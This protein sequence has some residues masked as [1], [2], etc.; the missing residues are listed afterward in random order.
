MAL[1]QLAVTYLPFM[2]NIFGTTP[3]KAESWLAPIL[4]GLVVFV[5]VEIEKFAIRRLNT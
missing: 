3:L 5:V 4:L 1:L 2:N